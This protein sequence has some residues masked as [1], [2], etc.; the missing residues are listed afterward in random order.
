M[1]STTHLFSSYGEAWEWRTG[2]ELYWNIYLLHIS[3]FNSILQVF[4]KE[5]FSKEN[6]PQKPKNIKKMLENLQPQMPELTMIFLR[7]L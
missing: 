4:L 6:E 3:P 2:V 7:A 5:K 1:R